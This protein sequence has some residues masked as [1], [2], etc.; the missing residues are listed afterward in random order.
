[1]RTGWLFAGGAL[2]L[3]AAV[4]NRGKIIDAVTGAAKNR[5]ELVAAMVRAGITGTNERAMFLAQMHH[6][7]NG[8]ARL[9]ESFRYSSADRVMANSASARKAGAA[10]VAAALQAGPEALAEIMY[11]GRMGNTAKGD[12]YRYRGRGF[13]QLTGRENY[14]TAGRWIGVDL[15]KNPELA[16]Q[17]AIAARIA[18]WY[19]NSRRLS[20]A[21][22]AGDVPAV[23]RGINGGSNGLAD[24]QQLFASYLKETGAGRTA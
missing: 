1:M 18:V 23:T 9:E 6:E 21:A 5:A 12:A 7:S 10:A 14:D 11:G 3:G 22:K 19:W 17:P 20:A 16:A 2:L 8:F 4:M 13:V 24:R 15:L